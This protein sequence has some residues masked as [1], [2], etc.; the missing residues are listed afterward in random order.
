MASSGALCVMH[1]LRTA[2]ATPVA[3]E[4]R[5]GGA[6]DALELLL[7]A[8]ELVV[9]H[10]DCRFP[11]QV[12]GRHLGGLLVGH[13]LHLVRHRL[14]D[15]ATHTGRGQVVSVTPASRGRSSS[16]R[17]GGQT[18]HNISTHP[19]RI[20]RPL[21]RVLR[22]PGLHPQLSLDICQLRLGDFPEAQDFVL[23]R[24]VGGAR[25]R[26]GKST[27]RAC[28][29]RLPSP[30][31][32]AP[33][34]WCAPP[35][36]AVSHPLQLRIVALLRVSRRLVLGLLQLRLQRVGASSCRGR[37]CT[38][39]GGR[40]GA[41]GH[42][43]CVQVRSREYLREGETTYTRHV[44]A[45]GQQSCVTTRLYCPLRVCCR[46]AC[47]GLGVSLLN[48]S[49]SHPRLDAQ[50]ARSRRVHKRGHRGRRPPAGAAGAGPCAATTR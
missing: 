12:E 31:T 5:A 26:A 47:P 17:G 33:S 3:R 24:R 18:R 29:R 23:A 27:H 44:T 48:S 50:R 35:P 41:R 49:C 7:H 32:E 38:R 21:S 9:G 22:L 34:S 36:D 30:A 1:H 14:S 25:V 11:V 19:Q 10:L 45:P 13:V 46:A 42:G 39:L 37:L 20:S 43:P 15:R 4:P 6:G 2:R 8:S 28:A 40:L 16:P